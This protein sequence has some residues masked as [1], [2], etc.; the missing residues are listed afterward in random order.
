MNCTALRKERHHCSPRA[1]VKEP[2]RRH[3]GATVIFM[4][5]EFREFP[6]LSLDVTSVVRPE[7]TMLLTGC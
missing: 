2:S 6:T 7:V 5:E 1:I 3:C 4:E